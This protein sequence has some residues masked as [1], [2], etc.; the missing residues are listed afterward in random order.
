[1]N[2]REVAAGLPAGLVV[3][4]L[5]GCV[6]FGW[7]NLETGELYAESDGRVI[8]DAVGAVEWHACRVH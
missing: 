3:F 5:D 6:Q 4:S 1:M 8:K 7:R 2:Q